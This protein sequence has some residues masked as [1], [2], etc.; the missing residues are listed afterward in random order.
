MTDAAVVRF[1]AVGSNWLLQV[2]RPQFAAFRRAD[3]SES[4]KELVPILHELP[5]MIF[6]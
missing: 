2:R 3:Y 5:P 6:C 1:A 4:Q